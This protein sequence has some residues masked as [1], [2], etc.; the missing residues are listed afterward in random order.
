MLGLQL[1]SP[2]LAAGAGV[3]NS[4]EAPRLAA[5]AAASQPAQDQFE[6]SVQCAAITARD[7]SRMFT[8]VLLYAA[9]G[10]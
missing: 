3:I 6:I 1:I 7:P 8:H 9:S 5:A 2:M 4:V 10:A